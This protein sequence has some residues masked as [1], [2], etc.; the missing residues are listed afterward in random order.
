[1]V[2]RSETE[3]LIVR[4]HKEGK[5]IREIAKITIYVTTIYVINKLHILEL[6]LRKDSQMNIPRMT[7]AKRGVWKRKP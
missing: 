6:Y 7:T 5:T 1:M 2:S 4:L 3:E